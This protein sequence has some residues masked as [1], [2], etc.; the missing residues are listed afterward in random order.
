MA[1]KMAPSREKWR[2]ACMFAY[3]DKGYLHLAIPVYAFE[4]CHISLIHGVD[5][6]IHPSFGTGNQ[7]A[8]KADDNSTVFQT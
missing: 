1:H 5:Q 2:L 7:A 4:G 6:Q 3:T 8:Y